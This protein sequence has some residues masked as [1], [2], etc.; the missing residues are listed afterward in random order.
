MPEIDKLMI[1]RTMERFC[2][3]LNLPASAKWDNSSQGDNR[4]LLFNYT[5]LCYWPLK[6]YVCVN[7]MEIKINLYSLKKYRTWHISGAQKNR[8][9]LFSL[10]FW[11]TSEMCSSFSFSSPKKQGL[12]QGLAG[13]WFIWENDPTEFRRQGPGRMK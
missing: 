12:R 7:L 8:S 13:K 2:Q 1:F 9:C 4:G 5:M 6:L 11:N 10:K 3:E